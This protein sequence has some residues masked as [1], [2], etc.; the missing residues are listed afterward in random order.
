MLYKYLT[1]GLEIESEIELPELLPSNRLKS[2]DLI[3][4]IGQTPVSL[5]NAT[6]KGVTYE[7]AV[8]EFLLDLKDIAKFY[9]KDGNQIIIEPE[10]IRNDSNIR[11][12]LL[13]SCLGAI[14][15][16][17]KI[18]PLHASAIVHDGKAVLFTGISGAGKSTTANAFRLKGF[19]MLTDDVCP[20]QFINNKPHA[21]PGYPQ[22]KLWE[23]ALEKMNIDYEN[24]PY[25]RQGIL[26]RRVT[27]QDDFIQEPTEIKAIYIL[28]P[29]N[30]AEVNLLK[31]EDSNKFLL[32][33][34]MT[35]RKYLIRD[36]G[37]QTKH[38][39]QSMKLGSQIPIKR[40]V[41]PK[42]FSL[43]AVVNTI[44]TDLEN[45]TLPVHA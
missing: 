14:L 28:Q 7:V 16:Q 31:V 23:E 38:F 42:S 35:Y 3:I 41:R 34:N 10:K 40:I 12:F 21:I 9:V 43:D 4:S 2:P 19:K 13:G 32:I 30:K 1:F 17:R 37:F 25:T 36:L 29:H 33:K 24:L 5:S 26:K 20:I 39:Q 44:T 27:I 11:L 22:S 18:L 8:N 45:S 6:L 15:H